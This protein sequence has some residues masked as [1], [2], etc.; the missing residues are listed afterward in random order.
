VISKLILSTMD[1]AQALVFFLRNQLVAEEE[2]VIPAVAAAVDDSPL[3]LFVIKKARNFPG[4]FYVLD[5]DD[6]YVFRY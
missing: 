6:C 4:F 1:S 3:A 2:G 5:L